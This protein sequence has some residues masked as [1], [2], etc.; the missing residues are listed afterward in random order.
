VSAAAV[1]GEPLR[2]AREVVLAGQKELA[3]RTGKIFLAEREQSPAR[4]DEHLDG[5]LCESQWALWQEDLDRRVEVLLYERW[6]EH[7]DGNSRERSCEHLHAE[8]N[9]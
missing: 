1:P 8:S 6:G 5:H 7:C 4:A 9:G 3:A 2:S